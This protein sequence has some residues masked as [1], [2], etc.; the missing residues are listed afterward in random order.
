[1]S[2]HHILI[3]GGAGFIGH[4]TVDA[5]H[6]DGYEVTIVDNLS[7]SVAT[8]HNKNYRFYISDAAD[9]S[10]LAKIF[11]N[12]K[13]THVLILSSVV[14][15]PLTLADPPSIAP[16]VQSTINAL[17]LCRRH[18]VRR[19]IYGSSGF[20]YGNQLRQPY[21]EASQLIPENPYNISK[22]FGE[23]MCNFYTFAHGLNIFVLRYA[24]V[25]GPRRMIGPIA[26]FIKRAGFAQSVS[27]NPKVKRDYIFVDDVARANLVAANSDATLHGTYNI[28][29]GQPVYLADIYKTIC[30]ISCVT[31]APIEIRETIKGEIIEF[32]MDP[33]FASERINYR[34][35]IH[36][37]EGLRRTIEWY[38]G[39]GGG[40]HG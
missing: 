17:E 10:Q 25:Y 12:H 33:I 3:I 4:A 26:D 32:V 29:T 6:R 7:T 5:F 9:F 15:V 23:Q 39:H 35:E 16:G 14:E 1:M 2:K 31:E 27:I 37:E 11:A 8:D 19:V 30:K 36:I 38:R 22:I 18:D 20:V 13:F 34:A 40:T 21:T 28:C 24:P